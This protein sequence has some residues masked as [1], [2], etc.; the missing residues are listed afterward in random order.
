M[1]RGEN[2]TA[3][4]VNDAESLA[5]ASQGGDPAAFDRLVL[6]YKDRIYNLCYRFLG[7][8]ADAEDAAQDT[9]MKVYT[10]INQ[11]K[12]QS[13]F[14]TWLY[15]IAVNTC[16]N[17]LKSFSW[18]SLFSFKAITPDALTEIADSRPSPDMRL[19]SRQRG[20][21]IEKAILELPVAQRLVVVLRDIEGLSY[22]EISSITGLNQGTVKS[23]LSRA[24][25]ALR[26]KL[27]DI[28]A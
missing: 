27:K 8:H 17:K 21:A 19:Q 26:D 18:K 15:R 7:A 6:M 24:R 12:F 14:S 2:E 9:F 3:D 20:R 5:A 1:N 16:K 13:S 23:K 4:F 25:H 28:V 11:F 22:E 10:S